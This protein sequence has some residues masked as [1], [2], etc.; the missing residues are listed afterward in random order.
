MSDSDFEDGTR[1]E[2]LIDQGRL[3]RFTKDGTRELIYGMRIVMRAHLKA[4][5]YKE[6]REDGKLWE[7]L[8][9]ARPTGSR[10]PNPQDE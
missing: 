9:M 6:Y 7:K 4:K 10:K 1:A 2:D 8:I 5:E 3:A